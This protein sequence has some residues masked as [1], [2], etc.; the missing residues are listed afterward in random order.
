MRRYLLRRYFPFSPDVFRFLIP[1]V[2]R[3]LIPVVRRFLIPVVFRFLKPVVLRFLRP[4]SFLFASRMP[5]AGFSFS[6][7][8]AVASR[9]LRDPVSIPSRVG[10]SAYAA[11]EV[12]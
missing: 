11:I 8:N 5:D 12:T 1:D 10:L 9:M 6:I 4:E 3:F 2:F 7:S